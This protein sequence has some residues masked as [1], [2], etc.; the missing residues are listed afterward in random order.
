MSTSIYEAI[1]KEIVEAMKRGDT[2][3]RDYARVVK[4]E[5]DR[6]GDGRP[7]PDADA[8]KI[9]KALRVTAEENQNAFELAFLDRYL[10]Q[11]M[12]E[13]EIEAWIRANV[14]FASLKSP[15]AAI[16]IVTKALG[17]AAPG[18]RVRKVVEK[19]AAQP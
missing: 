15:M 8:V 17:P 9:L 6:K 19:I 16:G 12:S 7:L 3:T 1:K 18:D 2:A 5:L 4:A 10:P 11:E 14:D 13:A